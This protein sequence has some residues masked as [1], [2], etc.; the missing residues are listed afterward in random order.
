MLANKR[1]LLQK[2][3]HIVNLVSKYTMFIKQYPCA[4][5]V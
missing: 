1:F 5:P 3:I 2:A 4:T